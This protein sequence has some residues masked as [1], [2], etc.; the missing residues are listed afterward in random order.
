MSRVY[1]CVC[2][3]CLSVSTCVYL[4]LPVSVSTCVC[5][6]SVSVFVTAI[7]YHPVVLCYKVSVRPSV[8]FI[9]GSRAEPNMLYMHA[10]MRACLPISVLHFFHFRFHVSNFISSPVHLALFFFRVELNLFFSPSLPFPSSPLM[11][12]MMMM[13]V[14]GR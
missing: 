12:M 14:K 2:V 5:V 1:L 6:Y 3:S 10:C 11:M 4:C 13:I 8:R 7:S 9:Q